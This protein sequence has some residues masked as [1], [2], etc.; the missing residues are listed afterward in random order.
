MQLDSLQVQ[1][2]NNAAGQ[3]RQ[4]SFAALLNVFH[5]LPVSWKDLSDTRNTLK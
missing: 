4:I 5:S 1:C 2:C 3:A